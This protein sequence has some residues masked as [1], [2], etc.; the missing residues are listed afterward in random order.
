MTTTMWS[1]LTQAGMTVDEDK[2]GDWQRLAPLAL[3]FIILGN[4]QKFVREN[5]YLFL[6]A[7]AGVAFTEWLGPRELVLG[8]TGV[9]LA[10]VAG[11]VIYHRRFRFRLEDDAIRVRRGLFEKKELRI[12]F[13]RVQNIQL[14]Q[15][16]YFRPFDLVRFSLE[17]P[18]AAQ[19]EVELPGI[20]RQLA[21]LMRDRI[22]GSQGAPVDETATDT[23]DPDAPANVELFAASTSR[24]FVHGMGSN[25]VWLIFS[26]LAWLFG[27]F[28]QRF[29]ERLEQTESFIWLSEQLAVGWLLIGLMIPVLFLVLIMVSGLLSVIRFHGFRLVER[30][31]RL[32]GVG[33]LLD[34]REQT[35]RRKKVTGLTLRQTGLG[36]PM[37]AWYLLVRQARSS[38]SEDA[39][40]RTG[41]QVPGLRRSNHG[42]VTSIVPGWQVP[43]QFSPISRRFQMV[44]WLRWLAIVALAVG[45]FLINFGVDRVVITLSMVLFVI[46]FAGIHLRWRHWGWHLEGDQI[47][48]RRGLVGQTLDAFDLNLVQQA[49]ISQS[50]YQRRHEL[51]TLQLVL[52]QGALTI[53]FLPL[54][55][56]ADLANRALYAAETAVV[57]RV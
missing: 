4:L 9:L 52:P 1:V 3:I 5:I 23:R 48:I 11:A 40:T 19:K 20:S 35:I 46:V 50:P 10:I 17:T 47:W 43:K 15:P 13:A 14:G 54:D 55:A 41:F 12:R 21:E 56:A 25:Q 53:P 33:G 51:A 6:G 34:K 24:L 39:G 29:S 45:V 57:H 42:L 7:G 18:G 31:D 38:D 30:G 49:R 26:A 16:F 22:A 44:F 32:V 28:F 37:G 36:R 2:S 27:V 8:V